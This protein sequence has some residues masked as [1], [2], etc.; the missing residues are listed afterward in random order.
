MVKKIGISLAVSA[1]LT[2]IS[3]NAHTYDVKSGWNL[4]GAVEDI[5]SSEFKGVA[6]AIWSY[7]DGS[8]ASAYPDTQNSNILLNSG[9]GFWIFANQN[10]SL[11]TEAQDSSDS[12]LREFK[13]EAWADNWF[14]AYLDENLIVEDSVSITTEK[15]FNSE[16]ATFKANYPLNLNFII[17]DF[18]QNDTGLEYIGAKNQQ[19]GDGGFIMQITDLQSGKVV[20]VSDAN[21][22]CSILHKA[23]L[24]KLCA[25]ESNPVAG[26]GACGYISLEEPTNWKSADFDSSS[27]VSASIYSESQIGVKDGYSEISW[28]SSAKLIW[29]DDLEIDNTLICKLTVKESSDE[30][31]AVTQRSR[32]EIIKDSFSSF[33]DVAVSCD[34][35]YAYVT[36]DTFP[37]H[38]K[39]NGI[40]GTNEQIPVP[41]TNYTTPIVLNPNGTTGKTTID[42]SVAIA[43]NGVPIYDYS[44]QGDLDVD[45]YD[46]NIDTFLLG[47]LDNCG[48]HAGRGDDYHYHARPNCMIDMMSDKTDETIIGWGYDGY[49]LYDTNNPDGSAISDGELDV[50]HGK[51]DEDF[52]YRY[53]TSTKAPYVPV[54]L[55]GAIDES[56]LPRVAPMKGRTTGTPPQGGVT[57][58]VYSENSGLVRMDYSYSGES[59]YIQYSPSSSENCYIFE[60]KTV[61]DKGQVVSG[62]FCR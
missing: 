59:Y 45:N 1:L 27:F 35:N 54:C 22:K 51:V 56:K 53:H 48:G 12:E 18:K 32:C 37:N 21:M 43:V 40:T 57:N 62:E 28:D 58:L 36:S 15:S 26:E 47:Q 49:P 23:P 2:Q 61:T 55:R 31:T 14:S 25:N 17:K 52:G 9:R 38:D 33:S 29:G 46:A 30:V 13:L 6:S 19:M 11:N 50:C 16:T 41:A 7:R 60:T 20:A 5:N 34:S 42:A 10:G 39:M 8:W 4:L 24:D 44:S 3:L